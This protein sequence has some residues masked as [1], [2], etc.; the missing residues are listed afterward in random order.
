L[1]PAKNVLGQQPSSSLQWQ[2]RFINTLKEA[3]EIFINRRHNKPAELI[4]RFLDGVLKS[5]SKKVAPADGD[6]E[7]LIDR[8]LVLFRFVQGK[9]VFEA[10]YKRDLAK[11]LLLRRS[12]SIDGERQVLT[13]LRAECGAGFTSKLDGMFKD[14]EISADLAQTF[15]NSSFFE[16]LNGIDLSVDVLT[17]GFWPLYPDIPL[18]IPRELSQCQTVFEEFHRS[19]HS[20]RTLKWQNVLG[21]CLLKAHFPKSNHELHVSLLQAIILLCFNDVDT[22]SYG[23]IKEK[24]GLEE[25]ELKRTLQSLACGKYR[26]LAKSPKV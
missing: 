14:M 6:V 10:F 23:Q 19:K 24:I 18:I 2:D 15:K 17:H 21:H 7:Q 22:L 1:S 20:G 13:K 4:A 26:V 3:F 5:G 8:V 9:D 16:R 25:N 11:R 12:A